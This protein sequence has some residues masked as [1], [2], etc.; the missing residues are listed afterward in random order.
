MALS[1]A[2]VVSAIEAEEARAYGLLSSELFEQREQA[3][4]RYL[5]RPYGDEVVG[6]SQ[7]VS[8]DV[9]DAVEWVLPSLLKIFISGDEIVRFDPKGPEDEEQAKQESDFINYTVMEKNTAFLTFNTWFKDALLQKNGYVK[10]YWYNTSDVRL[11]EYKGLTQEELKY[12][13]EDDD[14]EI[15][16]QSQYPDP[17]ATA[18]AMQ[19]LQAGQPPIP[20]DQIPQLTDVKIRRKQPDEYVR[21]EAVPP[22]EV[23][24]STRA[25]SVSLQEC[26]FVQH[27]SRKTISELRAMGYDLPDDIADNTSDETESNA[28]N[29]FG[30]D[31]YTDEAADPSMREVWYRENWIR[32]DRDGDGVAELRRV[33]VVGTTL[34]HDEETDVV[35][36]ACLT[37][38]VMPHRHIGL[39]YYDLIQD[40]ARIKTI[41]MRNFL[42]NLYLQN[43]GRN[44][45]DKNN[46]NLEDML[47]SRPGGLVR[48][49][50]PPGQS[51]MPIVTPDMS[52]PVLQGLEYIDGVKENRTG[53]TK[54]NQGLDA[55]TLNKTAS[56]INQIMTASQA[57]IEMIARCFAET[58]VKELFWLV[59]KLT[60]QHSTREQKIKLRNK[61]V[62]VNPREWVDRYNLS[63]NVGLGTGNKDQQLLHLNAI[64]Q[65]QIQALPQGMSTLQNIRNTLGKIVNNSGF[66]NDHEF[67]GDAPP[68]PPP[69]QPP[70]EVQVAQITAQAQ[71]QIS[72]A[73]DQNQY[74]I[75]QMQSQIKHQTDLAIE[76]MKAE[77]AVRLKQ[78]ENENRVAIEALKEESKRMQ[79]MHQAMRPQM[80]PAQ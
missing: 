76:T 63:I 66:K 28:R 61:W 3:M 34:L 49:D 52:G 45:I 4:D 37:P 51:I 79:A 6:R 21:F 12:I 32:I 9:A 65:M 8:S 56:G 53:V 15:V 24:V 75:V 42:D 40:L 20:P 35:N 74:Q 69:P 41:L 30:E 23:L 77:N 67:F 55:N 43:N 31:S 2:E 47:V 54:Y 7:I 10:A 19:A 70:P 1:D 13:V 72:Q 68:Q 18:A 48:T 33:C 22:E 5:G 36:L 59:H 58:G 29:R 14:V 38:I 60:L 27:R 11:E 39:S 62:A 26:P 16:G 57:R 78:M 71:Q 50:G 64:L 80:P 73:H 25:R 17:E 46:V 44:A